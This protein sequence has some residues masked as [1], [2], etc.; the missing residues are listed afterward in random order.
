MLISTL[1]FLRVSMVK[2]T[3]FLLYEHFRMVKVYFEQEMLVATFWDSS[4]DRYP[5]TSDNNLIIE[6]WSDNA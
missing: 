5:L 3:T 6:E 4:N 2:I 1:P